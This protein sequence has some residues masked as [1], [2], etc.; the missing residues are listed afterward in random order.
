[1]DGKDNTSIGI[2]CIAI[3]SLIS[4]ADLVS[5][6][7]LTLGSAAKGP[8]ISC[9]LLTLSLD[10]V[11]RRQTLLIQADTF[12]RENQAFLKAFFLINDPPDIRESLDCLFVLLFLLPA[13]FFQ[14]I[15]VVLIETFSLLCFEQVSPSF[16][17]HSQ[18][19]WTPLPILSTLSLF[20]WTF[21]LIGHCFFFWCQYFQLHIG[22]SACL[23]SHWILPLDSLG[24]V[25]AK[26]EVVTS[27]TLSHTPLRLNLR[28]L[29]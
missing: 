19:Q 12:L 4:F 24:L 3:A 9:R 2:S 29:L 28:R 5:F 25:Q 20:L 10:S 14:S 22:F 21:Q 6:Y 1:M 26:R 15:S 13:L 18:F 8:S 27:Q 7:P 16:W 17:L 11:Y 23:L